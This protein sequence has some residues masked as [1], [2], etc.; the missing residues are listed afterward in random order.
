MQ[1]L[2]LPLALL[3][4]LS[5][6]LFSQDLLKATVKIKSPKALAYSTD[7]KYLAVSSPSEVQILNAGSDT[8]ATTLVNSRDVNGMAFSTDNRTMAAACGDGTIKI[9]SIPDGKLTLTLK[10]H[11]GAVLALRFTNGDK[12]LVSVGDDKA[13]NF[14]DVKAGTLLFSKKDHIKSIRGKG[15]T[16]TIEVPLKAVSPSESPKGTNDK[17]E[18]RG[19]NAKNNCPAR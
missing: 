18:L 12:N 17:I 11:A 4:L 3:T 2:T 1:K 19:A 5:T 9:W 13:V 8:K 15:T 14:W 10:G 7:N 16:V 6:A